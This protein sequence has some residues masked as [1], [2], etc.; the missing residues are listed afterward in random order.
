MSVL[1]RLRDVLGIEPADFMGLTYKSYVHPRDVERLKEV[2]D[3]CK[4][5]ASL[6]DLLFYPLPLLC[7]YSGQDRI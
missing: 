7:V 5:S 2:H 6:C 1:D 3:F 4:K